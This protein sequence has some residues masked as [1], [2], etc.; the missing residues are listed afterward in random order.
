MK[1]YRCYV[2]SKLILYSTLSSFLI[3]SFLGIIIFSANNNLLEKIIY[4]SCMMCFFLFF[5]L[6]L[7]RGACVTTYISKTGIRNKYVS[8]KWSDINVYRLYEIKQIG[9][10]PK[11][12]FPRIVC[13]GNITSNNFWGCNPK[14]SVCFSL[15]ERNLKIIQDFCDDK[16]E[17]ITELLFWMHVKT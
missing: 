4:F 15:T 8:F 10:Y 17:V 14:S 1:E 16:N 5:C 2:C 6:F 3:I 9:R 7:C 13:I 12:K 11:V